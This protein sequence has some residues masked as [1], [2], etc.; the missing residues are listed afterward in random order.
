MR[1]AKRSLYLVALGLIARAFGEPVP[2]WLFLDRMPSPALREAIQMTGATLRTE[3]RWFQ[4]VSVLADEAILERV[5]RLPFV[6]ETAPVQRFVRRLPRDEAPRAPAQTAAE[7]QQALVRLDQLHSKG[8]FGEGVRIGVLDTGF[9][10]NHDAFRGLRIGDTYD[11]LHND[12]LVHDEPGEDDGEE[13]FHGTQVLALLGGSLGTAPAAEFYLAKTED[14]SQ[15]GRHIEIRAEEDYW[16]SGLEWCVERGCRVVNSSLGYS[17]FYTFSDLDGK[18]ARV[19]RA[20]EEAFRRGTLVVNAAGNSGG[21]PP[22]DNSLRGRIS[23][24]ADG[25]HVLAVGA[26]TPEGFPSSQSAQGPTYDGRIKPD[27]LALGVDVLTVSPADENAWA[28]VTGTSVAA[29]FGTAIVA[30]LIQAFPQAT[31]Q[32]YLDALRSTASQATSPNPRAGY[33]L[34]NAEAAYAF[35]AARYKPSALPSERRLLPIE[36]GTLKRETRTSSLSAPYPNPTRGNL[37]VVFV[38]SEPTEVHLDIFDV[39][40]RQVCRLLEGVLTPGRHI[41]QWDG[42]EENG[43]LIARGFYCVALALPHKIDVRGFLWRGE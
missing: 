36:W 28:R 3:S 2:V 18:T 25:E 43:L 9:R 41:L 21:V 33:G 29:P 39:A 17:T 1:T 37:N 13:D 16:I 32:D 15:N 4:A 27:G 7:A 34:F 20:A 31:P 6:R 11:F 12:S 23:P 5:R 42:R 30:L 35:L 38:L 10:T 14:V 40:G 19:T 26:A 24:P 22:R 8:L